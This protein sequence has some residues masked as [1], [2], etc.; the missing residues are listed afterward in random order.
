MPM[1]ERMASSRLSTPLQNNIIV[2][3]AKIPARTLG[4]PSMPNYNSLPTY[5]ALIV[6][7]EPRRLAVLTKRFLLA[8]W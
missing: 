5:K 4:L 3:E 1:M 6:P 7:P 2:N 8:E